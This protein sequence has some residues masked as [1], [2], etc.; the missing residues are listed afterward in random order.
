M[1]EGGKV[2]GCADGTARWHEG[3]NVL[4]QEIE[5]GFD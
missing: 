2:A 1:G 3:G 5:N 4:I